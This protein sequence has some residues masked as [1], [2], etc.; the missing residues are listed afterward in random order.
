LFHIA[1]LQWV[2]PW[3]EVLALY[4]PLGHQGLAVLVTLLLAGLCHWLWEE[5]WR[6]FGRKKAAQIGAS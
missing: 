4:F 6:Q 2:L 1:A 5:P 3:R